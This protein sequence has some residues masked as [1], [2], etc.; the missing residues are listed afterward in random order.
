M[1]IDAYLWSAVP[2]RVDTL[3][4][5]CASPAWDIRSA[6]ASIYTRNDVGYYWHPE[7]EKAGVYFRP[8]FD[9]EEG[10]WCKAALDRAVG[11]ESVRTEPLSLAEAT[12]G[13]WIKVAYSPA[14]RHLGEYM[15][16]FPRPD[17]EGKKR[18]TGDTYIPGLKPSPLAGMLTT[19]LV[20]GGL[21]YGLGWLGEKVL[22]EKWKKGRLRKSLAIMG[23]LAGAAPGAG[24]M[25]ANRMSGQPLNSAVYLDD[26]ELEGDVSDKVLADQKYSQAADAFVKKA[27][28][29]GAGASNVPP[30][31]INALG[32]TLW[33][34]GASPQTAA[35]TM[36]SVYAA[37]QL[38]GG[39]G[40]GY[41]TPRQTGLLGTM[42][43][44]AG[45]GLKGYAIGWGVGK[46]LGAITGMPV[47]TRKT[48]NRGGATLGIINSLLPR[49][50]N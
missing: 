31:N 6:T 34:V 41:V 40:P 5:K 46:A 33:E 48:L 1:E 10:A 17:A 16:F 12:D 29:G 23:A 45:G 11:T 37:Q 18:S 7:L 15:N 44:A 36:S 39:V 8:V 4:E 21:G 32:Q 43:G 47:D 35:A 13:S 3:V 25:L 30:V 19:G 9:I 20:G 42:M 38:P 28:A 24:L 49:L 27:F 26:P 2:E 50:F 14:L 22:P